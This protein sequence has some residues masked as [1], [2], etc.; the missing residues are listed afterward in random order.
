MKMNLNA[1]AKQ[2]TFARRSIGRVT[3][4]CTGFPS[5]GKDFW[6]QDLDSGDKLINRMVWVGRNT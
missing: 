5:A 2:S 4:D 1:A 3:V 6:E